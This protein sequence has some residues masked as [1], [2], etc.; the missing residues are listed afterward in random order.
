VAE[1][2]ALIKLMNNPN[3]YDPITQEILARVLN[4]LAWMN[5]NDAPPVSEILITGKQAP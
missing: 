4:E 3:F 5:D 1:S 2:M